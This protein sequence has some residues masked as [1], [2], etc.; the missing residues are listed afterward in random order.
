MTTITDTGTTTTANGITITS[1]ILTSSNVLGRQETGIDEE[2]NI[3]NSTFNSQVT[4]IYNGNSVNVTNDISGVTYE[5]NGAKLVITSTAKGVEYIVSGST[6]NGSLKIYSDS[7]FKLTLNGVDITSTDGPAINIQSKKRIFVVLPSGKINKLTD[8]STYSTQYATDGTEEDAKGAFF[9]EGQLLFSGTGS[10]SVTANKKHGIVSD[11]YVRISE[12]NINVENSTLATGHAIRTNDAVYIDGGT[13]NLK[14][15]NTFDKGDGI[16]CEG[17]HIIINGGNITINATDD[18]ITAQFDDDGSGDPYLNINGGILNITAKGEG[19]E[20]KLLLTINDGTI[21]INAVDDAINAGSGL[22]FNGG[23]TYVY[24]SGN[25]ALDT[26]GKLGITGGLVVAVGATRTPETSVDA[27]D[28]SGKYP[29]GFTMTG[30]YL[31]A[32]GVGSTPDTPLT[33]STQK[34]VMLGGLSGSAQ[35]I[36]ITSDSGTEVVTFKAPISYSHIMFSNSKIAN[37]IYKIYTGGSVTGGEDF[38]GVYTSGI[39][40]GGTSSSQFTVSGQVTTSGGNNRSGGRGG[41]W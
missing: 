3:I 24:S 40:T 2:D 39:Y 10:I 33:T 35:I 21:N 30:G 13:I 41:R 31:V 8:S 28:E 7:K 34:T 32:I 23:K 36:N 22:Y 15:T 20:S 4:I 37:G 38:N 27:T 16:Q 14:T 11:D 6:T 19:I 17:G 12:G 5:K 9:S 29:A 26:N 1:P 25:D 18:G